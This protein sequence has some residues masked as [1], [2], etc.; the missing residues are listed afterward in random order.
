M[1]QPLYK[2]QIIFLLV[3]A[4]RV[5]SAVNVV[6]TGTNVLNAPP[7]TPCGA[8]TN[9]VVSNITSSTADVTW[10][11]V[12][13]AIKYNVRKR[14]VGELTWTMNGTLTNQIKLRNLAEG[15]E[16]E[17][18]VRTFCDAGS[19]YG[20]NSTFATG[21]NFTTLGNCPA[22]DKLFTDNVTSNSAHA[23]W[24]TTDNSTNYGIRI[25]P[26]GSLTW[27]VYLAHGTS[28]Q[29]TGLLS[30]TNYEWQLRARCNSFGEV[31]AWSLSELFTTECGQPQNI[32]VSDITSSSAVITWDSSSAYK[33]RLRRKTAWDVDWV[34]SSVL[35]PAHQRKFTNLYSDATYIYQV[36][37]YCNIELTDSSGYVSGPMFTT[38][39]DCISPEVIN[40][41]DITESSA[42]ANWDPAVN[43]SSY[44]VRIRAVGDVPWNFF[45]VK[46]GGASSYTFSGLN[47]STDY[48]WQVRTICSSLS[49]Y[50]GFY[51]T[52]APF[53]TASAERLE[54]NAT[55]HNN[56][57]VIG[58]YPNPS[59][60]QIQLVMNTGCN[61]SESVTIEIFNTLGQNIYAGNLVS[62]NGYINGRISLDENIQN[63]MYFLRVLQGN[64]SFET[65]FIINK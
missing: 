43:A 37:T 42:K 3:F 53:T 32:T 59:K 33:Y 28:F 11:A 38:G 52:P 58:L 44:R 19:G 31:S 46:G 41:T 39:Q 48:E 26:V 25:R 8:V 40:T 14:I 17:F 1:K 16:Y 23:T 9:I 10:D 15:S 47:S 65:H 63:G 13:G 21:P 2:L 12:P 27:T 45:V 54:G 34:Y 5:S 29:F 50:S 7:P 24:I 49:D 60:G 61:C 4:F 57:G 6:P 20:K 30:F 36:Q 51:D 62:D 55:Q 56:Y 35:A 18:E 22:P 64:N